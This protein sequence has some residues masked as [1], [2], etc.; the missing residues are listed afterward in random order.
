MLKEIHAL[1][2]FFTQLN[3]KSQTQEENRTKV[4]VSLPLQLTGIFL[5]LLTVCT[6]NSNDLYLLLP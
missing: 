1:F 5:K 6:V 2:I 3:S 4:L